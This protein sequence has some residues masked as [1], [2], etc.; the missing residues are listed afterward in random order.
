MALLK[1]ILSE[2]KKKPQQTSAF[3]FT[4]RKKLCHFVKFL[5]LFSTSIRVWRVAL[6][7]GDISIQP[8]YSTEKVV[9]TIHGLY[10]MAKSPFKIHYMIVADSAARDFEHRPKQEMSKKTVSHHST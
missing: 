2:T 1:E 5:W 10:L 8:T 4:W 3:D 9:R 6:L 7:K